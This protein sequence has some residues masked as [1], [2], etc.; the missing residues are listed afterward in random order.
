MENQGI[1]IH[2]YNNS[3]RRKMADG[4]IKVYHTK[5]KYIVKNTNKTAITDDIKNEIKQQ[6]ALGVPKKIL[7][8]RFSL[9]L[10]HINK[11][12]A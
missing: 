3:Y 9:S 12:L 4:T 1:V 8:N 6:S 2:E 10:Y 11:I 7:A 5:K